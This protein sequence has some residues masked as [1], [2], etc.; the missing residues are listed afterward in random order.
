MRSQDQN[1]PSGSGFINKGTTTMNTGWGVA[2]SGVMIFNGIS[3]EGVDPFYPVVYGS[4]SN[5]EA[6]KL[7]R[8]MAHP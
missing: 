1:I 4:N 3:G 7:D 6:E 5:V 2:V 8:C